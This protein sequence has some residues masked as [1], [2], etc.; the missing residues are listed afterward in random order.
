[1]GL[2]GIMSMF[3]SFLVLLGVLIPPIA[4]VYLADYYG[5]SARRVLRHEGRGP[6]RRVVLPTVLSWSL[7]S[8]WGIVLYFWPDWTVSRVAA[9]DTL[10]LSCVI[11]LVLCEVAQRWSSARAS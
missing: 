2:A 9:I 11:Y 5:R 7:A 6:A 4:G 1:M 10:M 3:I 8:A